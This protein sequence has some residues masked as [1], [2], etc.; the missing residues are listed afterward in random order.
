MKRLRQF[1][2]EVVKMKDHVEDT[3]EFDM[4]DAF[5]EAME[6]SLIQHGK[7]TAKVSAIKNTHHIQMDFSLVGTIELICDR[8]LESFDYPIESKQHLIFKYGETSGEITEDI[9]GITRD[10]IKINVA[11]YLY[12]F[13]S[14]EIPIK[15][16]HP[17]FNTESNVSDED[18]L[19]YSTGNAD[20]SEDEPI[21]DDPIDPRWLALK[22]LQDKNKLN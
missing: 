16:I 11:Q 3:Y 4:G 17:R 5:F 21:G 9:I 19:I 13:I 10:T 15:K 20:S 2:I 8:S 14:I 18:I 22:S 1:D 7:V 6:D 12:E